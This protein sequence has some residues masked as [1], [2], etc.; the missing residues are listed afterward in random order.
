MLFSYDKNDRVSKLYIESGEKLK[1]AFESCFPNGIYI[2]NWEHECYE[3]NSYENFPIK[4]EDGSWKPNFLPEG[5]TVF[6]LSKNLLSGWI[7]DF[8][9]GS[10]IIVGEKFIE[11]IR[12]LDFEFLNFDR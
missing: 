3:V 6:F 2:L 8:N 4:D 9:N 5:D 12:K 10:I 7:A 11:T 1:T